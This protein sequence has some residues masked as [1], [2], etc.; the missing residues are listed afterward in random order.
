MA[1]ESNNENNILTTLSLK[2]EDGITIREKRGRFC[3][4]KVM[5]HSALAYILEGRVAVYD[6]NGTLLSILQSG[7]IYGIANLYSEED[8]PASL[9]CEEDSTLIMF[10]KETVRSSLASSIA[11]MEAYCHLLNE[12]I[13]FLL[14]RITS[15]TT[16]SNRERLASYL[17]SEGHPEFTSRL[18]LA[19]YLGMGRSALFRELKFFE[20]NDC[21]RSDGHAIKVLNADHIRSL[22]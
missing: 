6:A 12:K 5:G 15:L 13:S 18:E 8:L 11:S 20:E 21:I 10:S 3:D 9:R 17:L 19:S 22:I 4:D 1:L 7:D 2:K 14:N 16:A